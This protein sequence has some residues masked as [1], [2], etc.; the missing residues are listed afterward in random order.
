MVAYNN[1]YKN[2]QQM[3]NNKNLTPWFLVGFADGEACFRISIYKNSKCKT[4]WGII[5]IFAIHLHSKDIL[6]LQHV[7][8]YFGVGTITLSKTR[9]SALYSVGSI[10][11]LINV[12]IPH[13]DKYPLLTKK[14][15]QIFNYL[16]QP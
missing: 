15:G 1:N 2:Y 13:F 7:Q 12:I 3:T 10:K 8:L 5:P 14:N 11:D 16:N 4:G 9:D 6:L